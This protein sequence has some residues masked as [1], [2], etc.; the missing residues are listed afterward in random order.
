M[1]KNSITGEAAIKDEINQVKTKIAEAERNTDLQT[2]GELKYGKLLELEKKVKALQ[3]K[4]KVSNQLLKEEIDEDDIAEIVSKWTGIP[5]NK[6]IESEME[7]LLKMEDYIH[8]R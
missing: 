6:L 2:A 3:G 7:K 8:K 5:V 4:D 1:E